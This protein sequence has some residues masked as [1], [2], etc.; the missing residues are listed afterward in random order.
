MGSELEGAQRSINRATK[1]IDEAYGRAA[2]AAGLSDS[3]FDILYALH[4][5]GQGCSQKQLCELC[6][7]GKQTVNSSIKKLEGEGLV[8]IEHGTG[9][10]TRIFLTDEGLALADEHIAPVVA[11]ELA[12]LGTV[13]AE[14]LPR[15]LRAM[16]D[17]ADALC[18]A[19]DRIG[20]G[21]A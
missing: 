17:Y 16:G 21:R 13:P 2:R 11:A 12:A 5:A 7:T 4:V 15:L 3:A 8:R 18:A 10:A 6:F 20:G 14:R 9:R 19:L 1:R